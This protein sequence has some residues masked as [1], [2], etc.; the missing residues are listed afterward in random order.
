MIRKEEN[1][2]GD[3]EENEEE[4]NMEK[5]SKEELNI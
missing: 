3:G 5:D 4:D 2:C 1:I